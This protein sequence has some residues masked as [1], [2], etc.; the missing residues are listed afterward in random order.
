MIVVFDLLF[1]GIFNEV[2]LMKYTHIV[3]MKI[4]AHVSS[5]VKNLLKY[6]S[7]TLI[8]TKI[9]NILIHL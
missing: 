7:G 9:L 5:S 8:S 4:N 6:D 1:G 2:F 3:A